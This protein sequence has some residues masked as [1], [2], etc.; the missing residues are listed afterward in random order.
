MQRETVV[1]FVEFSTFCVCRFVR[2]CVFLPSRSHS[3]YTFRV[4]Q[5]FARATLLLLLLFF[6]LLLLLSL[7]RH[8]IVKQRSNRVSVYRCYT[9]CMARICSNQYDSIHISFCCVYII[10]FF[11]RLYVYIYIGTLF[12]GWLAG[13]LAWCL[14]S[15]IGR[16]D[17]WSAEHRTNE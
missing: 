2:V 8:F 3:I 13:W 11:C 7:A 12:T 1:S 14:G 17:D 6:F 9:V 4:F 10:Y 5:L 15:F 16:L